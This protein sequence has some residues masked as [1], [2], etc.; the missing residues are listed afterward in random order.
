MPNPRLLLISGSL[1]AQSSSTA[2]LRRCAELS[3]GLFDTDFYDGLDQLPAFSPDIEERGDADPLFPVE[4]T[5]LRAMIGA[6]DA[7]LIS[8]PE[9]AHGLPGSLKNAV[10]WLVGSSTFPG[11]PFGIANT[12]P[13]SVHAPAQLL[14][15]V[16]TMSAVIVDDACMTVDPAQSE[17]TDGALRNAL[18]SLLAAARTRHAS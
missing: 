11:I 1:R 4:A 13:Q 15:I 17:H 18:A 8:T 2:I 5:R 9:Y 6:A 10:D 12:S 3:A 16:R 14:E 7:L